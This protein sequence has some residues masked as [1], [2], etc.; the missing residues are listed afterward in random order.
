MIWMQ[1]LSK[2]KVPMD[3]VA[4]DWQTMG[5]SAIEL[6]ESTEYFTMLQ[7][8]PCKLAPGMWEKL[9]AL[10]VKFNACAPKLMF[11]FYSVSLVTGGGMPVYFRVNFDE[12]EIKS[13]RGSTLNS[14]RSSTCVGQALKNIEAGEHTAI[15]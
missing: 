6:P 14:D 4:N 1:S 8:K 12:L 9:G 2:L 5:V 13:T 7:E 10:E 15:L 3:P 11:T